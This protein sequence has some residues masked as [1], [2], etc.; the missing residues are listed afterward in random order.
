MEDLTT[1]RRFLLSIARPIMG[2]KI[3]A[4]A[5]RTS[6]YMDNG[7]SVAGKLEAR[8][9]TALKSKEREF[10]VERKCET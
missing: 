5:E 6:A 3:M 9:R 4:E 7:N 2:A 10:Q 1:R 8:N